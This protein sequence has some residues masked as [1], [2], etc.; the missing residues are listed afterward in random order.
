MKQSPCG[1]YKAIT[2]SFFNFFKESSPH[3]LIQE[4]F[5]AAIFSWNIIVD[6][7]TSMLDV[8]P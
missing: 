7:F 6:S 4:R 3:H 5:H 2:L 1:D 8:P